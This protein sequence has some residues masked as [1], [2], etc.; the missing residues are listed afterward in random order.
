MKFIYAFH[1]GTLTTLIAKTVGADFSWLW[2]SI[3][4]MFYML[5]AVSLYVANRRINNGGNFFNKRR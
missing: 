5:I 4:I 3:P 2:F 1:I